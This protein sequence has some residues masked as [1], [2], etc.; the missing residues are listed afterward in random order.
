[1][2][3]ADS[4]TA[5]GM[6]KENKMTTRCPAENLHGCGWFTLD[7]SGQR[8]K[9]LEAVRVGTEHLIGMLGLIRLMDVLLSTVSSAQTLCLCVYGTCAV[10]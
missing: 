1:M 7:G 9:D 10:A 4:V 6:C 2:G 5:L 3:F 8:R